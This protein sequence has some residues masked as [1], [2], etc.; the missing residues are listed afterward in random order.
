MEFTKLLTVRR[1]VRT[2]LHKDV[3]TALISELI[4]QSTAAPSARKDHPWQFVIV[5][6]RDIMKEISEST[7]PSSRPASCLQRRP[8]G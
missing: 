8:G 3:S 1:S 6:N 2:Y 5:N 4:T 7:A